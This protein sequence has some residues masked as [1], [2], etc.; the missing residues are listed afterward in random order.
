MGGNVIGTKTTT[1]SILSTSAI[2]GDMIIKGETG[3]NL[4]LQTGPASAAMYIDTY[5]K[6]ALNKA[7]TCTSS[8]NVSGFTLLQND[9]N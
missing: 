9:F 7:T 2:I 8:L 1:T 4:I 3:S 5:N 6:V